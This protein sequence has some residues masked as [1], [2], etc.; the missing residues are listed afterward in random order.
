MAAVAN[1]QGLKIFLSDVAQAFVREKVD[2]EICMKLPIGVVT[3][4]ER[5]F[6]LTDHY[7]V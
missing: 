4:Q 5:L 1:E 3:C 6:G 2:A 7:M